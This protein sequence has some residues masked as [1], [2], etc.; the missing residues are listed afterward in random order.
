MKKIRPFLLTVSVL[1]LAGCETTTSL[2]D[3]FQN[4]ETQLVQ[5]GVTPETKIEIVEVPTPV[6]APQ[7]RQLPLKKAKKVENPEKAIKEANKEALQQSTPDGFIN[8]VQIYDYMPVA[9]F[10]IWCAPGYVSTVALKPGE[11]LISA[12]AGDT[13]RWVL[14]ETVTGKDGKAQTLLLLKPVRPDIATNLIVTTDQRVYLMEAKAVNGGVY[15]AAVT[16]NYP[17]DELTELK[18]NLHAQQLSEEQIIAGDVSVDDLNFDYDIETVSS[19]KDP[20]WKPVQAF[21]DGFKT[22]IRFPKNLGVTEAPPLFV[23]SA[24]GKSEIVN[25]RVKQNYYVIDRLIDVAELRLGEQPQTV[26]E[27]R[28]EE[29]KS[30]WAQFASSDNSHRMND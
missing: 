11:K 29:E 16:W 19:G 13:V 26:V 21:D 9:L 25:Y 27:I 10:E 2:F 17:H 18:N 12:S 23:R 28:K 6:A 5:A 15:N 1:A 8:A 14:G 3:G 30:F 24:D 4:D 22:Y 7:L 20:K